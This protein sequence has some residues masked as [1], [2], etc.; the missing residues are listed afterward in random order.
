MYEK[1]ENSTLRK[2]KMVKDIQTSTRICDYVAEFSSCAKSK[3]N[4]LNQLCFGNRGSLSFLFTY[5]HTHTKRRAESF[6]VVRPMQ[7]STWKSKKLQPLHRFLRWISQT[8][9]FRPRFRV[10]AW[11]MGDVIYRKYAP[12]TP[13]KGEWIGSFKR[14]RRNLSN[15][16]SPEL[17]KKQLE[18][19]GLSSDHTTH[20]VGGPPLPR[21]KLNMTDGRHLESRYDAIFPPWVVLFG[22]NLAAW[23]RITFHLRWYGQNSNGKSNSNMA[24]VCFSKLKIVIPHPRIEIFCRN[25]VCW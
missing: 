20:F 14:K 13:Q 24:E 1:T 5:T 2:Y 21:S 17:F 18:I 19:W 4:R 12:K 10:G 22:W 25:L 15:A 3:Q 8:S 11:T 16:I 6:I 23:C 7:K 9:L